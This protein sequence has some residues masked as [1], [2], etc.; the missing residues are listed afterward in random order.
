MARAA[1]AGQA[2]HPFSVNEDASSVPGSPAGREG[3]GGTA[4]RA[5]SMVGYS[6]GS[7]SGSAVAKHV[8][9]LSDVLGQDELGT[10]AAQVGAQLDRASPRR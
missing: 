3:A 8:A 7:P 6:G 5:A 4:A 9:H 2:A 1:T 10:H